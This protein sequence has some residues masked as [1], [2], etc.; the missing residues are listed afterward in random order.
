MEPSFPPARIERLLGAF[1]AAIGVGALTIVYIAQYGYGFVPCHLCLYQRVPY[2]FL[3]LFGIG[4][5]FA[6]PRLRRGL[7]LASAIAFTVGAA[8]AFYHV[9]VEQHWWASAV[10]GGGKVGTVTTTEQLLQSLSKPAEKA[11]DAVDWTFLRLSMATWN[12][13]FS[14][15]MATALFATIIR[16]KSLD[17]TIR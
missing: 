11:C 2:A 16:L 3:V 5:W 7:L 17:D 13:I 9:G 4:A 15:L 1:V 6:P 12:A 10:C 14:A 8:I